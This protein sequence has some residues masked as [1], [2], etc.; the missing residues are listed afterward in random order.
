MSQTA[1]KD[2]TPPE[3]QSRGRRIR[4][5]LW[6]SLLWILGIITALWLILQL[7][8]VQKHMSRRA[9][10]WLSNELH[11]KVEVGNF[12]F[13]LFNQ[14]SLRDVYIE[15]PLEDTLLYAR[16]ISLILQNGL[17]GLLSGHITIQGVKLDGIRFF[18]RKDTLRPDGNL[19]FL[20]EYFQKPPDTTSYPQ[21]EK[22][23]LDIQLNKLDIR[24]A[25][26]E[27][28]DSLKGENQHFYLGEGH[29][30]FSQVDLAQGTIVLRKASIKQ[31]SLEVELYHALRPETW[32]P[33]PPPPSDEAEA[34]LEQAQEAFA[35]L[36]PFDLYVDEFA[37]EKSQ[38]ALHNWRREPERLSR[39]DVLD[40]QHM[41]V[42]DIHA[43]IECFEYIRDTFRARVNDMSFR[44]Q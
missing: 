28:L 41:D 24:D 1:H 5:F 44:A 34:W 12:R 18:L 10:Q 11:T 3:N 37:L 4:R 23:P 9:A 25:A 30:K 38:F 6:R 20:K 29:L 15:D 26:F 35:P 27:K 42:R 33:S 13:L 17:P 21:R 40:Y 19:A 32:G 36:L 22:K 7:P 31:F 43:Y 16:D 2:V 8:I 39:E 14:W